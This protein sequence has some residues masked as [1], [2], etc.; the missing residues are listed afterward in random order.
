M[1]Q[2]IETIISDEK[3]MLIIGDFN[4]CF[5][6]NPSHST[7]KFLE[8]SNFTQL[9]KGPTHL[10]GH[11]LDQA[12]LQDVDG[13]LRCSAEVQSKYYSDHKALAIMVKKGN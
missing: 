3:P 6:D 7:K 1:N 5:L 13:N 2:Y 4:F 8:K 9:I 11:L 12:Y 10:E